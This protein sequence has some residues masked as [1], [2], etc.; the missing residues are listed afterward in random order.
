MDWRCDSSTRVAEVTSWD[1]GPLRQLA[2][3]NVFCQHRPRI[4][5]PKDKGVSPYIPLQAGYRSK[6]QGLIH[7]WL[8]LILLTIFPRATWPSPCSDFSGFI[9][10]WWHPYLPATFSGLRPSLSSSDP[11]LC[12]TRGPVLQ[13]WSPEFKPQSDHQKKK[14]NKI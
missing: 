7:M 13:A 1:T 6:K 12:Y 4:L 3:S 9:S 8:Y 10:F 2:G 5:S 14:R 11:H